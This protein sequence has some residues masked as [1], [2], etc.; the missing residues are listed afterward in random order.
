MSQGGLGGEWGTQ[1]AADYCPC[2][3][4]AAGLPCRDELND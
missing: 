1:G 2:D 4:L 3:D